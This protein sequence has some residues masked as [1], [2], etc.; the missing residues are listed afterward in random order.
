MRGVVDDLGLRQARREE[1]PLSELIGDLTR[2]LS[3]LMRHEVRLA[4]H[5]MEQKAAGIGRNVGFVAA[6]GAVAY[7]GLLAIIAAVIIL[8]AQVIPWWLS[9]LVVGV[10]VAGI[11]YLVI[12]KG[13]RAL[14]AESLAPRATMESLKEDVAW[15][16]QKIR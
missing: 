4:S 6:G 5:E 16:K 14:K 3:A 2:Q 13:L 9:A 8:L 7:A 1:A 12:Q 15:A 11:G 10:I